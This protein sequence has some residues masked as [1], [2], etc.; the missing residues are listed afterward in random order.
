MSNE[1]S[2]LTHAGKQLQQLGRDVTIR[3]RPADDY[4]TR[5][6]FSVMFDGGSRTENIGWG[7]TP[8]AAYR[9]LLAQTS[10]A[11]A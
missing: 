1:I 5:D 11:A 6:Q 7:E 4:I 8:G 3:F 9:N 10:K 2:A